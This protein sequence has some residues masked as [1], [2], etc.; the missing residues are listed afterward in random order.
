MFSWRKDSFLLGKKTVF[1]VH[2]FVC[3]HW[4]C[5]CLYNY[6]PSSIPFCTDSSHSCDGLLTHS[7]SSWIFTFKFLITCLYTSSFLSIHFL[8]ITHIKRYRLCD[9]GAGNCHEM[10]SVSTGFCFIWLERENFFSSTPPPTYNW[11]NTGSTTS[12]FW[13]NNVTIIVKC[14]CQAGKP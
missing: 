11:S 3:S 14:H 10:N 9:N 6:C 7:D 13:E 8:I 1:T 4:I 2:L 12:V 5:N